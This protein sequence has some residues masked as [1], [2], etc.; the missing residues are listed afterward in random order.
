M[1]DNLLIAEPP[2]EDNTASDKPVSVPDKFW[3]TDKKEIRIDG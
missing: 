2:A 1:T 3:D